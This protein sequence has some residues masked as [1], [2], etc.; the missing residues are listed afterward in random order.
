LRDIADLLLRGGPYQA[1]QLL[2][3]VRDNRSIALLALSNSDA[4]K[5]LDARLSPVWAEFL[6]C[7]AAEHERYRMESE[8]LGNAQRAVVDAE[9]AAAAA[10]EADPA[11]VSARKRVA[12]IAEARNRNP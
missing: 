2:E 11:V 9:E 5:E 12:E 7:E 10:L 4:W 3:P 6:K 8:E 1:E